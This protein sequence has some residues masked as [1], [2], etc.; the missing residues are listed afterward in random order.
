MA[1]AINGAK[2]ISRKEAKSRGLNRYFTGVPC[3]RGHADYR[4]VSTA[5]C[6]ACNKDAG[7]A[8]RRENRSRAL[9]SD[10]AC[11]ARN[12]E[13]FR[14]KDRAA[15]AT[16]PEKY[17][18]KKRAWYAKNRERAKQYSRD[19]HAAADESY[20]RKARERSINYRA[21]NPGKAKTAIDRWWAKN[22]D[23]KK[24]YHRN[25]KARKR[26]NGGSHTASDIADIFALQNGRCAYCRTDLKKVRRHVD[27]V[28]PLAKGGS[29]GRRNLQLLCEP[30]NLS[31][32]SRDP[33]DVM[34]SKGMLL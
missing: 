27:H 16:N 11:R 34:R 31:K 21:L 17:R 5:S 22:P 4:L 20:K 32:G 8:W 18:G 6:V 10:R 13:K 28:V 15:Y 2:I 25:R 1:D 3:K 7:R 9:A 14:A 26:G 30:C 33:I 23:K 12:I 24:T 29:N 19:Y